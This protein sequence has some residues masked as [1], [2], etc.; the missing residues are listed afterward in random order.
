M[1]ECC[2]Y[3]YFEGLST[4]I[5]TESATATDR[6][7]IGLVGTHFPVL[8]GPAKGWLEVGRI[9]ERAIYMFFF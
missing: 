5:V 1:M 4:A 3:A 6:T 8:A 2:S 9:F 7:S